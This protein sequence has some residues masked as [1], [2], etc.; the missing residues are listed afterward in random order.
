L[1]YSLSNA[2]A[3]TFKDEQGDKTKARMEETNT[4]P[5]QSTQTQPFREVES[6]IE[7]KQQGTG[8]KEK[9]SKEE[10]SIRPIKP[11]V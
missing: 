1:E 6:K 8:E 2:T 7:E 10:A 4:D 5:Y 11:K 3:S 9:E